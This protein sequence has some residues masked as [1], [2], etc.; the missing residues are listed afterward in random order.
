MATLS[1]KV[2]TELDTKVTKELD[3]KEL[4][5]VSKTSTNEEKPEEEE[6]EEKR[7]SKDAQRGVRDVQAITLSWTRTSLIA[8]FCK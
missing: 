2:E 4:E 5:S 1:E 3:S 6:E 8:V 7:P